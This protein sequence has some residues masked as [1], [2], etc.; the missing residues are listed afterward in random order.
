MCVLP[1]FFVTFFAFSCIHKDFWANDGGLHV[2]SVGVSRN[3]SA[4]R[5]KLNMITRQDKDYKRSKFFPL[6]FDWNFF[7]PSSFEELLYVGVALHLGTTY[8]VV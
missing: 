8:G 4:R 3:S 6:F 1:F 7:F 5:A 2:N